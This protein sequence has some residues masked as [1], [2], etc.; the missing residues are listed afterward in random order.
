M[1]CG[2]VHGGGDHR[3]KEEKQET[4]V[5]FSD[6]DGFDEVGSMVVNYDVRTCCSSSESNHKGDVFLPASRSTGLGAITS[7]RFSYS[8][9][10][11]TLSITLLFTIYDLIAPWIL[12]FNMENSVDLPSSSNPSFHDSTANTVSSHSNDDALE[13]NLNHPEAGCSSSSKKHVLKCVEQ[14]ST[15]GSMRWIPVVPESIKHK[16]GITFASYEECFEFYERYAESS[17]FDVKRSSQNRNRDKSVK[18][19]LYR[20]NRYGTFE[21]KPIDTTKEIP[22][23]TVLPCGRRPRRRRVLHSRKSQSIKVDCQACLRCKVLKD[24]KVIIFKFFEAHNHKLVS[25]ANRNQLKR[26]RRLNFNNACNLFNLSTNLNIGPVDAHSIECHSNGGLDMLAS[27]HVDFKNFQRDLSRTIVESDAHISLQYLAKKKEDDPNFS[28][29]YVCAAGGELLGMFWADNICKLNYQEFGDI[30]SFD[31]TYNTNRYKMVFVPLTGVDNHKKLVVF[32]AALLSS[33]TSMAFCWFRDCFLKTFGKEPVL[34][35]TDQDLAIKDAINKKFTT[36]KHR[37]CMKHISQKLSAKV[38]NDLYSN[39]DFLKRM[40]YIFWDQD[41]PMSALMRTSSLSESENSFFHKCK[42]KNSTI[43]EFLLRGDGRYLCKIQEKFPE[44]R[45]SWNY[46]VYIDLETVE[47]SCSCLLFTREGRLCRHIFYVFNLFDI[48]T[49]PAHYIL[50]RWTREAS[51]IFSLV[52]DNGVK[53]TGTAKVCNVLMNKFRNL[54]F[55]LKDDPV[56]LDDLGEKLDAIVLDF[57]YGN[58][59]EHSSTSSEVQ[60]QRLIGFPKPDNVSVHAPQG[61]TNKGER[62]NKRIKSAKE[63][64]VESSGK[65][66]RKCMN[67]GKSVGHNKK[68]CPEKKTVDLN[69][70]RIEKI[71][72]QEVRRSVR[73]PKKSRFHPS[74]AAANLDDV[75]DTSVRS[76]SADNAL[77]D[78]DL[79]FM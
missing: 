35:A 59:V 71:V 43:F 55:K 17:G 32:G 36:A 47:T 75:Y 56:K 33:E 73:T 61:R 4:V 21:A 70:L 72:E 45:P 57:S 5:Q 28:Y 50:K 25:E 76:S 8:N 6:D 49:I 48:H 3:L 27:S 26:N 42:N 60:I 10:P 38:G 16:C 79:P 13:S 74:N 29:E 15:D 31:P 11:F 30:L 62:S 22:A 37:L 68:T 78:Q 39:K 53:N 54:V 44:P 41:T 9:K 24:G 40:N 34:V 23:P 77:V 2:E 66:R 65:K 63:K 14:L 18:Y 51:I 52:L 19:K 20:C 58:L 12:E 69:A 67:C 46:K 7:F 64:A 1:D